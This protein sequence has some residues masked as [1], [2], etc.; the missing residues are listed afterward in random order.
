M[1]KEC[2]RPPTLDFPPSPTDGAGGTAC[3]PP[4]GRALALPS[5]MVSEPPTDG[6]GGTTALDAPPPN[7]ACAR[8]GIV[9]CACMGNS[10]AGATASEWPI[11]MS[12][13][14]RMEPCTLGGGATT[15]AIGAVIPRLAEPAPTSGAGATAE[16]C[17]SPKR[18]TEDCFS[19]GDGAT[20]EVRPAGMGRSECPVSESGIAGSAGLA[21]A[22]FE[23]AL[24]ARPDCAT[25]RLGGITMPCACSGVTTSF[26]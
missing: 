18:R 2:T 21:A 23:T 1:D 22:I 15:A 6:G 11:L 16:A 7:P 3:N 12:P 26:C 25:I 10:G 13:A 19:S 17:G 8:P 20:A 14:L 5:P 24:A 4:P 9:R